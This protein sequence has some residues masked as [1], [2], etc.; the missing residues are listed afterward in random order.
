MNIEVVYFYKK[1]TCIA[2]YAR[3]I[4]FYSIEISQL[5]EWS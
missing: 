2:Q 5:A 1:N 3:F 4:M